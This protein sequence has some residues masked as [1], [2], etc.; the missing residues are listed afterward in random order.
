MTELF[1]IP[2]ALAALRSS[3]APGSVEPVRF[4]RALVALAIFAGI[5]VALVR[6]DAVAVD[7]EDG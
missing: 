4:L 6:R 7:W 3:L 2:S 1:A 5:A